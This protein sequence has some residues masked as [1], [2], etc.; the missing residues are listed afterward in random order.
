MAA[1]IANDGYLNTKKHNTPQITAIII[2]VVFM[3]MNFNSS[4]LVYHKASAC[5]SY[6]SWMVLLS[7]PVF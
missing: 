4:Y 7:G 5:I 3:V 6:S 2:K 1:P